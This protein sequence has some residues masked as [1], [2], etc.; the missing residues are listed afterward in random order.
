MEYN[1]SLVKLMSKN[2]SELLWSAMELRHNVQAYS[3][4]GLEAELLIRYAEELQNVI[5]TIS[6]DMGIE[7]L[8]LKL[9]DMYGKN[10][11]D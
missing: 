2:A 5:S 4:T 9:S 7:N 10:A 1:T 11:R 3:R 6:A 8:K